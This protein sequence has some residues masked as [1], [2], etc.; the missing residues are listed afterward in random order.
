MVTFQQKPVRSRAYPNAALMIVQSAYTSTRLLVAR[1][2]GVPDFS[3]VLSLLFWNSEISY[4][5]V[6]DKI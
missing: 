3:E 5:A 2:K 4:A 6:L 1:L